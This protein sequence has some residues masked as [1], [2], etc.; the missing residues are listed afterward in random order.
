MMTIQIEDLKCNEKEYKIECIHFS[1]TLESIRFV[2]SKKKYQFGE[3]HTQIKLSTI[4]RFHIH[5]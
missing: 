2:I 4:S 5:D 3:D 1:K